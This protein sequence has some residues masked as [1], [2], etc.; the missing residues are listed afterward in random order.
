MQERG[1]IP[2]SR[3]VQAALIDT[4]GDAGRSEQV[5]YHWAVREL[6]E[7]SRQSLSYKIKRGLLKI[8]KNTLTATL[9]L[10]FDSETF[11]GVIEDGVKRPIGQNNQLVGELDVDVDLCSQCKQDKNLAQDLELSETKEAVVINEQVYYKTTTKKLYPNGDYF[12]ETETPLLN[13]GDNYVGEEKAKGRIVFSGTPDNGSRINI[14]ID[15]P[16]WGRRIEW[17]Y[18]VK[19]ADTLVSVLLGIKVMIDHTHGYSATLVNGDTIE[20]FAPEKY[21]AAINGTSII[22]DIKPFKIFDSSF[23]KTFN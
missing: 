9:P 10:D 8:N 2:I 7:L 23:D 11:V 1:V 14:Y 18:V 21:G 22:V 3:V 16:V 5:F 17:Q 20:I 4:Y 6:K 13:Y 15:D 12:L 19:S